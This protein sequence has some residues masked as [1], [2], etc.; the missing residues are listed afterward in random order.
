MVS[1]AFLQ[2]S[3]SV[4]LPIKG[5]ITRSSQYVFFTENI[6]AIIQLSSKQNYTKF[7][8]AAS[9][10]TTRYGGDFVQVLMPG[11][12]SAERPSE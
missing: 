12:N 5:E 6:V 2:P 7:R 11:D 9:K 10:H 8:L 3:N 4:I 1:V